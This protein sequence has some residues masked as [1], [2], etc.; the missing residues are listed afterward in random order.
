MHHETSITH[1]N[2][3]ASQHP[4]YLL[5]TKNRRGRAARTC[6]DKIACAQLR[7]PIFLNETN[8][9]LIESFSTSFR[10]RWSKCF[11]I[12]FEF[13]ETREIHF[14]PVS[15]NRHVEKVDSFHREINF[16]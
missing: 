11:S 3:R 4:R 7:D 2:G 10:T 14:Y 15:H 16:W 13:D 8:N 9:L 1:A 12:H 6:H 5:D